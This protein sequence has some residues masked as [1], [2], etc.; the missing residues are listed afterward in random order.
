M[1]GTFSGYNWSSKRA[2]LSHIILERKKTVMSPSEI[3]GLTIGVSTNMTGEGV[4]CGL[5]LV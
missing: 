3:L 5:N 1:G 4:V 2:W